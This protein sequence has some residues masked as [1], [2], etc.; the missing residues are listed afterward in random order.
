MRKMRGIDGREQKEK[1]KRRFERTEMPQ[2]AKKDP[3]RTQG[4]V[5]NTKGWVKPLNSSHLVWCW[6]NKG[7]RTAAQQA[8]VAPGVEGRDPG[9]RA[10][11]SAA[12]QAA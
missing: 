12:P 3:R 6:W 10:A 9:G 8:C 4:D 1:E 5:E 11:G 7:C 2:T